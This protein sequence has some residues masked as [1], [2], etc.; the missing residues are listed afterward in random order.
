MIFQS[1]ALASLLLSVSATASA[2][3][4]QIKKLTK[5]NKLSVPFPLSAKLEKYA[6]M[7][8]KPSTVNLETTTFDESPAHLRG[9]KM[10]NNFLSITSYGDDETCS[11]VGFQFGALVNTCMNFQGENTGNKRSSIYKVNNKENIAV[12]IQ[13]EGYDCKVCMFREGQTEGQREREMERGERI[14]DDIL[15]ISCDHCFSGNPFEGL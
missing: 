3:D 11:T 1:A 2:K 9:L 12:E 14:F 7:T 13:Y 10:K 6:K 15:T 5:A 8:V 4:E